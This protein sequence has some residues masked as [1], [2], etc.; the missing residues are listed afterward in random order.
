MISYTCPCA[1]QANNIIGNV[2]SGG[3]AGFAFPTLREPLGPSR[4]TN[5]RPSAQRS[6]T[7]DGNTAHST[8]WW[9]E[10]AAGFYLG[11]SLYYRDSDNLLVYDAGRG[12]GSTPTNAR[13]RWPC[14]VDKCALGDCDS[15]CGESDFAWN[16]ITNSKMYSIY[17]SG[18]NSWAGRMEVLA[19]ETHD[20]GLA[21]EALESGFWIDRLLS[22]C[23][24]GEDLAM[25]R[26]SVASYVRGNGFVWCEFFC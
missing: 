25:P 1:F 11:G 26:E 24:T 7:I 3:W 13:E 5:M 15:W 20:V 18:L 14:L 9:W 23:R 2:A 21:L 4:F 10:K 17:G 12:L 16:K 22:T 8:G 19:I 6:K